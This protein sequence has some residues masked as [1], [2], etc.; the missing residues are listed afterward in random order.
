MDNAHEAQQHPSKYD[1]KQS[2]SKP[3]AL[4]TPIEPMFRFH[5]Q[6]A[7][8]L[9][10]HE[11]EFKIP[12]LSS[13][14]KEIE[15]SIDDLVYKLLAFFIEQAVKVIRDAI[16]NSKEVIESQDREMKGDVDIWG[17]DALG[18]DPSHSVL[19]RTTIATFSIP[20]LVA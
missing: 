4:W 8:F 16:K 13:A 19:S 18:S 15:D 7:K 3:N 1:P 17:P 9:L 6:I 20:L 5:D 12:I 2:N 11:E 14:K 10:E